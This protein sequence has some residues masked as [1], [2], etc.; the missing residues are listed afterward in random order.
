[1][2]MPRRIALAYAAAAQALAFTPRPGAAQQQP[3]AWPA[4]PGHPRR[5]L[6]PGPR[7]G[8]ARAVLAQRLS[9]QLGQPVVVDNRVGGG[10][11]VSATYVAQSRPDGHTVLLL[12]SGHGRTRR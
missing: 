3:A 11:T 12:T 2:T 1:M 4:R 10:G 9:E 5:R 6:R 7:C 8:R